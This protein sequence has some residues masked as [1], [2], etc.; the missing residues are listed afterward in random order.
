MKNTN[1]LIGLLDSCQRSS[2]SHKASMPRFQQLVNQDVSTQFILNALNLALQ[3][4]K[5]EACVDRLLVFLTNACSQNGIFAENILSHV[6]GCMESSE[7]QVRMKAVQL[8]GD[9][10]RVLPGDGDDL[11]DDLW[12]SLEDILIRRLDDRNAT[13]RANAVR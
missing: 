4:P 10:L 6:I 11:S 9:V 12:E 2:G 13:V 3:V 1:E 8:A 7:K 5:K